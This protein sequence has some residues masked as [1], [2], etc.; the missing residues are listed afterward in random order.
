M[1]HTAKP[2]GRTDAYSYLRA[3]SLLR[4]V[5]GPGSPNRAE[6]LGS[7]LRVKAA[8]RREAEATNPIEVAFLCET[9]LEP[10]SELKK[11]RSW[12]FSSAVSVNS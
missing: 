1:P 2:W 7:T 6:R 10:Y 3:Y 12:R 4:P 5:C 9:E 8:S 11:T